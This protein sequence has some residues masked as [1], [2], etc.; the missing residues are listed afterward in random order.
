MIMID[1]DDD[2]MML[3]WYG[4]LDKYNK[5]FHTNTGFQNTN[6]NV[7]LLPMLTNQIVHILSIQFY[8]FT[9]FY[10]YKFYTFSNSILNIDQFLPIQNL[11]ILPFLT[12]QILT[13]WPILTNTNFNDYTKKLSTPPHKKIFKIFPPIRKK[14]K[15]VCYK[16]TL[17]KYWPNLTK[18]QKKNPS[19]AKFDPATTQLHILLR[20]SCLNHYGVTTRSNRSLE[21]YCHGRERVQLSTISHG[22]SIWT[23]DWY[24]IH[25]LESKCGNINCKHKSKLKSDFK[26][27]FLLT[28]SVPFQ[29]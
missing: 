28:F 24:K 18:W 22:R 10:Q 21:R 13:F 27:L 20:C 1:D 16:L 11:N 6:T 14:H 3:I 15:V 2:M 4:Q 26:N 7:K 17:D 29:K 8:T 25:H 23:K 9:N 19:E 12:D 5:Q